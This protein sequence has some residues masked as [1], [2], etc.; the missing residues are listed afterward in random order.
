MSTLEMAALI[1]KRAHY[2]ITDKLT[3]EV[4]ILDVKRV[5]NRIDYKVSPIAGKGE[6]WVSAQK[7]RL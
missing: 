7:V 5:Y 4:L 1:G 2:A 3:I 6:Q